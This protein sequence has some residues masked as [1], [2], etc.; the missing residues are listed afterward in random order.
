MAST[1]GKQLPKSR[2]SEN[3]LFF[4]A[5]FFAVSNNDEFSVIA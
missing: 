2:K 3:R 5:V 4:P 1:P